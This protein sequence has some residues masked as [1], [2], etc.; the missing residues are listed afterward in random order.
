MRLDRYLAQNG[1]APSRQRALALIKAGA[2]TLDGKTETR[3]SAK[4]D[5]RTVSVTGEGLRYVSRGGLKL[6]EALNV[7][8]IDPA[9]KVCL[10]LG[11]S[12]GGFTDCLLQNGARKVYALDVGHG[13]L[14]PK[15]Q[16]HPAVVNIEGCNA[17]AVAPE[18]FSEIIDLAVSDLSF[19]SQRLIYAPLSAVLPVGTPFISLIKPQFEA[20]KSAVGKNGIVRD[21]GVHERVIAELAQEAHEAGFGLTALCASPI[22]GGDGNREYLALFVRGEECRVTLGAIHDTVNDEENGE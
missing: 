22:R 11:A 17:R 18:L 3:P 7:F 6:E 14:S 10:D 9:G 1:L 2:V 12:T 15:L 8:E 21:R 16:D 19:I 5:G 4:T 13:Q 20:G